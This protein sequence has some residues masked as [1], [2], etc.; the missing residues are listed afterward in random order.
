MGKGLQCQG[1][2]SSGFGGFWQGRS[3]WEDRDRLQIQRKD[4]LGSIIKTQESVQSS[5]LGD[6]TENVRSR[7]LNTD[8]TD[9]T[10][11]DVPV[12]SLIWCYKTYCSKKQ[13]LDRYAIELVKSEWN[14]YL[15]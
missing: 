2:P 6:R 15:T 4:D 13:Q 10:R 12:H 11:A 1:C 7:V 14:L 3:L 9:L 8:V 5:L